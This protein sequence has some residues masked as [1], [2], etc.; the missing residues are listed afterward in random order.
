M[1]TIGPIG[2]IIDTMDNLVVH[3]IN[4]SHVKFQNCRNRK[5]RRDDE[6]LII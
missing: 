6:S 1:L 4:N 3:C 2:P 5:G